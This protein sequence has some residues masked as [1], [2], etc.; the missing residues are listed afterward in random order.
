MATRKLKT[1]EYAYH[2]QKYSDNEQIRETVGAFETPNGYALILCSAYSNEQKDA[3]AAE[4][5]LERVSYYLEN[6]FVDDPAQAVVN[7]LVY[8][9]GY[10][11][12]YGYKHENFE[13][14]KAACL[15]V[16]IR[17]NKVYFSNIGENALY[18][19]NGRKLYPL[20][21]T[22]K[23]DEDEEQVLL[24]SDKI[25]TPSA[26]EHPF[27]PVDDDMLL[28][29]SE[30]FL[31]TIPEKSVKTILSDPMPLHTKVSRL[32]DLETQLSGK[33]NVSIQ[34]ITFYNIE[35]IERSFTPVQ[36]EKKKI[37]SDNFKLPRIIKHPIGN[38][39]IIG[40]IALFFFYM[41][42]DL[43][44]HNPNPSS[45]LKISEEV[46]EQV[47]EHT[48]LAAEK[49]LFVPPDTI[50]SV[51]SGDTWGKIYE[52]FGVCSWFIKNHKPNIGKFDRAGNPVAGIRI[53]I[54]L[55]YSSKENFN[56]DFYKEFST[57]KLGGSCQNANA[58][59]LKDFE[60][61]K[62]EMNL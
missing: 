53:N 44:I 12:E 60:K 23:G 55:M 56:P 43:F 6:D 31:E 39:I 45:D 4:I 48:D 19:F 29:C 54:P 52:R 27:I 49:A 41:V 36:N 37:V 32:V 46:K 1:F 50:Y 2:S 42:Y 14:M 57:E 10:I 34:L 28:I 18:F 51:K 38:M 59:F 21:Y 5:A 15:C 35:N 22:T 20:A 13:G 11:H 7:A 30:Q 9:S 16:L 58:A 61:I 24:G 62:N 40:M 17:D 25:I 8:A 33:E 26:C 47:D 3:K